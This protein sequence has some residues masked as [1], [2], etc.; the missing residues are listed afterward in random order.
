[1]QISLGY[2]SG[3]FIFNFGGFV[4]GPEVEDVVGNGLVVIVR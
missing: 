3:D 1:M 4:A 2:F